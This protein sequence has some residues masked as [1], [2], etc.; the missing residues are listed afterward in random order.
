MKKI[1]K[2][3]FSNKYFGVGEAGIDLYWDK[4]FIKE[5]VDALKVQVEWA[6]SLNLPIILHSR[7]SFQELINV[8]EE[9]QDG[10]LNGIFHCFTGNL[11]DAK[12]IRDVGFYMGIGGVITFKNGGL[13]KSL[14]SIP[15]DRFVLE[16]DAPYL[17]PTPHRGKRNEPSYT[18]L[19]AKKMA[20]VYDC[21]IEQIAEHTTKNAKLIFNF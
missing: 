4:S 1:E 15:L 17:T 5:Q 12:R 19:V 2:E 8:I 14:K 10:R 7:D 16:T 21:S 9:C 13:D 11:D 6:K 18:L 3:L 20:E